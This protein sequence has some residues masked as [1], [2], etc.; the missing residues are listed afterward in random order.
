MVLSAL[1]WISIRS[2]W[3]L[4]DGRDWLWVNLGLVLMGEAMLSKSLIQFS[5]DGF[6]CLLFSLRPDYGRGS[7]VK[8]IWFFVNPWTTACQASLS[9]TNSQSLLKLMSI[10]SVMLSNHLIISHPH[11]LPPSIFPRIRVFSNGS[12][13]HIRWL[14]YWNFSFIIR[15]SNEYSEKQHPVVDVTG[16]GSK[17]QCCRALHRNLEC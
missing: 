16:D 2:L 9:I 12:T 17:V 10:E 4:P 3:K 1:W 13:L 15:P 7:S 14:K 8:S 5:V 11:L 6:P